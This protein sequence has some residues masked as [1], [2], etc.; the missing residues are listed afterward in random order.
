MG[1]LTAIGIEKLS[2]KGR[3]SDGGGLYLEIDKAGLKRWLFRYQLNGKRTWLGLGSYSRKSNT[4][5]NARIAATQAKSAINQGVDPISLKAETKTKAKEDMRAS[6][7]LQKK[8]QFTFEV[9]ALEWI[10]RKEHEWLNIKHRAQVRNTLTDYVYPIIGDMPIDAIDL[11]DVQRCLDPI[12]HTK[13]ETAS[14]VRQR[15]ES[16]FSF[17]IVSGKRSTQNPAQW[18]GFLDKV[19]SSPEKLKGVKRLKSGTD[20]HFPALPY[21]NLPAFMAKLKKQSGVA[22]LAMEFAILTA[23][24]TGPV[25]FATWDQ[26]DLEGKVWTVPATNMKTKKEFKVALSSHACEVLGKLPK[27]KDQPF[28]FLGGKLG[29]PL[30]ENGMLSVL[31]RMDRQ[32]IT[33]HGFRS[34]FRDYIGEITDYDH[35]LAEYALAHVLKDSTEKAYARG[36]QLTKRFVMME[37]WGTYATSELDATAN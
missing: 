21:A 4:L 23:S 33:V 18:K 29:Q 8:D 6:K 36:E 1:K 3:H 7:E 14:R 2:T 17:A 13:T 31:K 16:V 27:I 24:R 30:S 15:M 28:V 10:S 22:A 12:W 11:E 26:F 25:R 5:A 32:D 34:T 35:R 20:G 9:C 19:Y 37:D